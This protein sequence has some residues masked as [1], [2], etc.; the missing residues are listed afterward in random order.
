[1]TKFFANIWARI[2]STKAADFAERVGSTFVEAAGGYLITAAL[3]GGVGWKAA[4]G[5][6]LASGLSAI[7]T[8][9]KKAP[10][11]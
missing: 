2:K 10:T 11:T 4:V 9:L 1:M 6:A 7:K 3:A 8:L 5:A